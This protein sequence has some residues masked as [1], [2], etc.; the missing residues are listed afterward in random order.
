MGRAVALGAVLV[1]VAAVAVVLLR[2]GSDYT[3]HAR[4]QNASQLVKGDN[5]QVAG[6]PIGSVSAIK[7]TSDGEAD[8]TMSISDSRY[9]PLHVGT[10]A[11]VR[12]ASL[13]GVANRYVDL[14][15]PGG[16]PPKIPSGGI[17]GEDHTTTAVDLDQL[18]N[19]FDPKT[20]DALRR[21][22]RG[23]STAYG[24]RGAEAAQGF[25]YLNPSLAASSRLFEELNRD[26]PLLRD[27][28]VNSSQLVTTIASRKQHLSGLVD[29]L[30]TTLTA[31]GSQ[32]ASLADAVHVFP[33]FM[34]RANTTFVNLRTTLDRLTGLVDDSKPVAKKL[35]PFVRALR[36]LAIQA[37]P[38]LRNL[39]AL[40]QRPGARNDLIEL[41]NSSVP[42]AKIGVGP[43]V[44]NGKSRPG[45][46]PASTDAL[47][48]SVPELAYARPYA[49]D[50]IG[51]FDDFS[52]SGVYD[53]LGGGSRAGAH[54]NLPTN[55][56]AVIP[57]GTI[58]DTILSLGNQGLIS[59]N[60]RN[61][62]P[63]AMERGTVWKPA[64]SPYWPNGYPCDESQVPL[65]K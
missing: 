48:T 33:S 21:L 44:R 59:L 65:G 58:K 53:A 12:Q 37:Q 18:F 6:A 8:I 16:N 3:V 47:K 31:I 32:K 60:Q 26:T 38:T 27:F 29:H 1:A 24:G 30:A 39:S 19:T 40:I 28:V 9:R 17:I 52:H 13:S 36:P 14:M 46:L 42:V 43:V 22:I 15:L 11:I 51:W 54:V 7:L 62:C 49:P 23:Y 50:L 64:P 25:L 41:T 2:S 56:N 35:R 4:F 63:G 34:R 61:R 10:Q 20:R 45:A 57:S 5:V 55:V